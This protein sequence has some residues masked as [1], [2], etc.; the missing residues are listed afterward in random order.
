MFRGT[1]VTGPTH[2]YLSM[3]VTTEAGTGD[4][5]VLPP[6]GACRHHDGLQVAEVSDWIAEG[7]SKANSALGTNY[8]LVR[9]EVIENDSRLSHVYTELARRIVLAAHEAARS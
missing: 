5:I 8:R 6:V 9:A 3:T 2:N 7:V 4:V 1:H